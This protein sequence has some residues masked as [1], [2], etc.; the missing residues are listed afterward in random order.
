ME[1]SSSLS[2]EPPKGDGRRMLL[3]D[4]DQI[5]RELAKLIVGREMPDVQVI[6]ITDAIGFGEALVRG[7][8]DVVVTEYRLSY[9]D[10]L[11]ILETVK[12]RYPECPVVMFTATGPEDVAAKA[13][14]LGLDDYVLKSRKEFLRLPSTLAQAL[15]RANLRQQAQQWMAPVQALLERSAVGTFRATLAGRLL[16]AN[17]T[18]LRLLGLNTLHQAQGVDL[19]SLYLVPDRQPAASEQLK[20]SGYL[21]YPQL[22]LRR[23]DG[24]HLWVSVTEVIMTSPGAVETVV[25][26]LMQDVTGQRGAED[27]LAHKTEQLAKSNADLEQ[28]A[29]VASHELQEPLRMVA[30]YTEMLAQRYQGKLDTDADRFIGYAVDG[31]RRMQQLVD[32]LL[33]YSRVGTR[34]RPFQTTDTEAVLNE[35]VRQLKANI[36]ASGAVITHDSLPTVVADEAQMVQL[37]QNLLGNAIKFR[38]EDTPRVH[39][40]AGLMGRDWVFAFQDNGVGI[41]PQDSERIFGIFQRA[42]TSGGPGGTGIGLALCKRIVDRHAGR[43]WVESRSGEGSVFKFAIPV[44][45]T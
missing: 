8:F 17:Q 33:T 27:E 18:L 12:S 28:F 34:G 23:P 37:F 24:V 10:G 42:Q 16:D 36:D 43:I 41:E 44:R 35:A 30:R 38:R 2:P 22:E 21:R 45:A 31:A 40:S 6:E 39:I 5:D 9:T 1:T 4:D 15:A 7:D 29:Y 3:I 19:H 32:D 20:E 14:K 25:Y 11:A 13:I 26:G